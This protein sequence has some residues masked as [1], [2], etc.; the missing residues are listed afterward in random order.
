[1]SIHA[2]KR[3]RENVSMFDKELDR[4]ALI[5]IVEG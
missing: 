5:G 4:I 1:M 3:I 2:P